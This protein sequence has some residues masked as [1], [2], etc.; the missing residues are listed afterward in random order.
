[1]SGWELILPALLFGAEAVRVY[2]RE[3]RVRRRAR[4]R[5]AMQVMAGAGSR[6]AHRLPARLSLP[7]DPMLVRRS[8]LAMSPESVVAARVGFA[9]LFGSLGVVTAAALG[10]IIGLAAAAG[11]LGFGWAYPDLW[12]RGAAHRRSA[13]I[14]R[15]APALLELV[16]AGVEAGVPLDAAL[17]GAAKATRDEL[18]E[19]L[20]RS[21]IS[22]AL[23]RPRGEEFRDLG[24]RTGA[25]TLAALGLALRL[26]DRLGMPLAEALRGQA[27]RSRAE[28]ARAVQER[29]ARAGPRIL[30]VVVFVLVPAALLPIA[31]AVALTIAGSLSAP[32]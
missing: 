19:E 17:A 29:A 27:V 22:I 24:E 10:G 8:G 30:A 15:A 13:V 7:P 14:E 23:G 3:P 28:A 9:V 18:A 6:L 5:A 12:V 16:A 4:R 26:S 21:R 32:A 20:D 25:P 11:M 1:V 2:R 31:A